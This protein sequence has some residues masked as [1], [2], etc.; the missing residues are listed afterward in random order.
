MLFPLTQNNRKCGQWKEL[1]NIIPFIDLT[2]KSCGLSY[3]VIAAY[4][5]YNETWK[6]GETQQEFHIRP[7]R[8]L[9]IKCACYILQIFK[10]VA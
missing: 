7:S 5:K 3:V 10:G 6:G 9:W 4:W 8:T 2:L 1:V